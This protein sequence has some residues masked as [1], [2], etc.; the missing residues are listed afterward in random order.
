MFWLTI[1]QFSLLL[2]WYNGARSFVPILA[3]GA[4]PVETNERHELLT[5]DGALALAEAALGHI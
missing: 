2:S 4:A 1:D 5:L 3:V